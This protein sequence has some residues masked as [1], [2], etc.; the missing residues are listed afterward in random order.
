MTGV[1]TCALPILVWIFPQSMRAAPTFSYSGSFDATTGYSGIPL[2]D[3]M[4]STYAT[5]SST[6]S[7]T[8]GTCLFMD[9]GSTGYLIFN[10]EL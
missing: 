6:A 2:S 9:G 7:A 5:I 1:Q 8:S 10:S 4:K 3:T